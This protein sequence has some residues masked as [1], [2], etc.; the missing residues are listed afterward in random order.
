MI[1]M[2]LLCIC[3]LVLA[4]P[5]FAQPSGSQSEFR[6]INAQASGTLEKELNQSAADGWRLLLLPKAYGSSTM[7]ALLKK[8]ASSEAKYEYKVL[9]ATRIGTLENEFKAA[10]SDGYDFRGIIETARVF[11]GGE[12]L[13]VLER[14]IGQKAARSEYLFLNTKKES[15]LEKEM[16]GA[17]SQG[18]V[19]VG[20]TRSV[21]RSVKQ[22][23]FGIMAGSAME[24]TMIL[25]RNR[26]TPAAQMGREYKVLTTQKRGTMEKEMNQ[27]AKEGYEFYYAAPGSVTIM[28]R[29]PKVKT[30]QYEYKI[31]GTNRVNT[32]EKEMNEMSAAGFSY[33]ATSTGGGGLAAIFEKKLTSETATKYETKLMTKLTDTSTNKSIQDLMQSGYELIDVTNL[34]SFLLVLQ[35]SGDQ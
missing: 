14:E 5:L 8:P 7:G 11:I 1:R 9:A 21:D 22:Q 35:K 25:G 19:P 10:I 26:E 4:L 3:L 33:R 29:D 17:A 13:I 16:D 24:L 32:M 15:T 18:Y 6:F 23:M 27:A 30:A 12:T 28:K 31:L 2:K 34:E 20:F